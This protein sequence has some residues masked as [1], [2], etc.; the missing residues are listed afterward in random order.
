LIDNLPGGL[1]RGCIVV[2]TRLAILQGWPA[3]QQRDAPALPCKQ[4]DCHSRELRAM[5][6]E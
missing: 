6:D 3:G 1:K 5:S 4:V 2:D